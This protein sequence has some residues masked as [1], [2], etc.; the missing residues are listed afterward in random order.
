MAKTVLEFGVALL[1]MI[2]FLFGMWMFDSFKLVKKRELVFTIL[3]GFIVAGVA[4]LV[5]SGI[6]ETS[7]I[8]RRDFSRFIAPVTEEV[9][10]LLFVVYI[11]R[12]N[13]VGFMIDAALMGFA[14]GAGFA[15]VENL[16]YLSV[17]S[18]AG[19]L[20]WFVRG[21]GT[22]I[23]HGG[24]TAIAAVLSKDFYDTKEWP[25]FLKFMPGLA[26]AIVIHSLFNMFILP[27]I[28]ST[29]LIV[30][31]LP[32]VFYTIFK[33]SEEHTRNWLGTG[34][35]SD[36]ELLKILVAGNISETKMGAYIKSI[37]DR[38]P[39][40]VVGDIICYLRVYLELS[41]KAKGVLIMKEN[42]FELPPDPAVEAQ[43]KELEYLDDQ[44]GKTGK[45]AIQPLLKINNTD[46]W[47]LSM[48]R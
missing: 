43:F 23:M 2:T 31:I 12:A 3:L 17:L 10:K 33:R 22:A 16:Y 9:L 38:F 15:I 40:L 4:I 18:E 48:M 34:L 45:L 41:V 44:I 14:V 36:M 8:S 30:L 20:T 24:T 27:P 13:K 19:L 46:L 47:Q 29:L 39:P 6:M 35:D 37:Q 25:D 1:P 11:I 28:T 5:N 21:F 32:P 26:A 7:G 42:G